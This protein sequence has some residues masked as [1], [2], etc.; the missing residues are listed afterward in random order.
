M[1][2]Y[3]IEKEKRSGYELP[4]RK[5]DM[6]TMNR[7]YSLYSRSYVSTLYYYECGFNVVRSFEDRQMRDRVVL[8]SDR[9]E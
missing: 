8:G 2:I 4:E 9:T 5:R 7:N 6:T 3:D 1:L